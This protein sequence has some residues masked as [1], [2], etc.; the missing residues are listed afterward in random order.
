MADHDVNSD[1]EGRLN[2]WAG[3]QRVEPR[4]ELRQKLIEELIT[5][6]TPVKPLPSNGMLAVQFLFTFA[7]CAAG[8]ITILGKAGIHMMTAAQLGAMAAILTGGGVFFALQLVNRMVP[9]NRIA[10]TWLFG[11]VPVPLGVGASM[12][13]LFPWR[14]SQAFVEE[15]WPCAALE[16]AVAIPAG[17]MFWALAR[18]GVLSPSAGLGAVLMALAV[19]LALLVDQ[20][21]CMFLQAPHLLFWHGGIGI[22]LIVAGSLIGRTVKLRQL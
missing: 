4:G 7:V 10:L 12:A 1:L 3:D 8:L 20:A 13:L 5:S 21:Q 18:R 11:L 17:A 22:V 19:C 6:L 9:G 14:M 16:L 2:A 15:G